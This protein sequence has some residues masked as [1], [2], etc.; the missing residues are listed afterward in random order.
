MAIDLADGRPWILLPGTLCSGAVFDGL[1]DGLDVPPSARHVISMRHPKIED[2]RAELQDLCT[3][4]AIVCGFSLGALVAAHLAC[5]LPAAEFLL[6]ALNPHADAP[7]KRADRLEFAADVARQGGAA[8][9]APRLP[10]LAGPRPNRTRDKILQMAEESAALMP[11]QT[12]LALDRPGALGSLAK[13]KVPVRL[14]T[15]S[16]DTWSPVGLARDAA[17]A[18]PCAQV[19]TLPGLGHYALVEDPT[20]C[21]RALCENPKARNAR[22]T[23]PGEDK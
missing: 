15:G 4:D 18:A 23:L 13:T 5:R 1:L 22:L 21:C 9:I 20:A 7:D 8:S 2:F 16:E 12:N 19:T 10:P 14:F 6:F 3:P 11:A 17:R